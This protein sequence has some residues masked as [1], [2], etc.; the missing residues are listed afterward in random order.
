MHP[1]ITAVV[2]AAPTPPATPGAGGINTTGIVGWFASVVL[3]ILIAVIGVI[4]V[5]AALAGKFSIVMTR[6]GIVIIG[7]A[8]FAS[9]SAL[10]LWGK[11]AVNIIFS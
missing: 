7:V 10:V 5:S 3:P 1:L 2:L 4:V 6:V 8:F 9:A 11:A